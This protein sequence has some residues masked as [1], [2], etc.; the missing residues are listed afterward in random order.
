MLNGHTLCESWSLP[1]T[2]K[3]ETFHFQPNLPLLRL[4]LSDAGN[5]SSSCSIRCLSFLEFCTI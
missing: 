1:L 5:A 3:A 4:L 2:V